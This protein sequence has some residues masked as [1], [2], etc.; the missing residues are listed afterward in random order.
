VS[1]FWEIDFQFIVTAALLIGTIVIYSYQYRVMTHQRRDHNL[2]FIIQLLQE[3]QERKARSWV[4]SRLRG[5]PLKE[6]TSEDRRYASR[7]CSRY[8][9]VGLLASRRALPVEVV[10]RGWAP[11]ISRTFLATQEFRDAMK[12]R[13]GAEYWEHFD[14]LYKQTAKIWSDP[15]PEVTVRE[16]ADGESASITGTRT[17]LSLSSGQVLIELPQSNLTEADRSRVKRLVQALVD[18]E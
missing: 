14:W 7:V 6:W 2:L 1:N 18:S 16:D 15:S 3:D 12:R 13:N 5:K 8:D 4:M 17:V 11:S 10:L 9:L